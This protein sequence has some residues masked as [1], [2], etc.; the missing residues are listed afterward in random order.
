MYDRLGPPA[1]SFNC[2]ITNTGRD[3]ASF[4]I[5]DNGR[6]FLSDTSFIPRLIVH[7]FVHG[8]KGRFLFTS[9]QNWEYDDALSGFEE[10]TAEG[11]AFEIIHEYVRSYPDDSATLQLLDSKPYQYWSHKTTCYDAIKYKRC[12]G[13]GSFWVCDGMECD[14]YSIAATTFQLM[15]KEEPDAYRK[16]MQSYYGKINN[17][18]D[19][20]VNRK[21]L[22]GMWA[23]AVPR[24]NGLSTEAYLDTIPVFQGH[25]L[26]EGIYVLS[27]VRPYG[28]SGDQQFSISYVTPDGA[29]W[30]ARKDEP[31]HYPDWTNWFIPTDG[32]WAYLDIQGQPFAYTVRDSLGGNTLSG[33]RITSDEREGS[34]MPVGLGWCMVD[35]LNMANFE[36]GLY[37]NT[38]VFS[39][40]I[41]HDPGAEESLYFL[42]YGG[43]NQNASDEYVIMVGVDGVSSGN[44]AITLDGVQHTRPVTNGA[45]VFRSRTWAF[46]ME[47]RFPIVVTNSNGLSN[48]YYRTL[49]EA[50]T[51]HN[52]FQ[53]QFIIVD[54]D[55]D[56]IED[57][58]DSQVGLTQDCN[59]NGD[60]VGGSAVDDRGQCVAGNTGRAASTDVNGDGSPNLHDAIAERQVL[61]EADTNAS[62]P[63]TDQGGSGDQKV[64][65]QSASCFLQTIMGMRQ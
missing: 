20:R 33:T 14:R 32:G 21:D 45:A 58:V 23:A 26:D 28:S 52:Y 44:V 38:V 34:G 63:G 6:T 39:N 13:A 49:I 22:L 10:A 36:I 29:T 60:L 61:S 12:T 43:L 7:E 9:D 5:V 24:I 18:P 8:W 59:G 30:A 16:I 25:Q 50:G 64:G 37:S 65:L 41:P 53:H 62:V 17:D 57:A 42:G 4:M 19:W 2:V 55:F 40:Y 11:M 3:S 47:G 56:G 48:T 35:E 1:E 54:R 27:E 51:I 31:A 15:V 46:D